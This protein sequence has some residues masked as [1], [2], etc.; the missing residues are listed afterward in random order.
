VLFVLPTLK[1]ITDPNSALHELRKYLIRS[2]FHA[3]SSIQLPSKLLHRVVWQTNLP[4]SVKLVPLKTPEK[5]NTIEYFVALYL[6]HNEMSDKSV[7]LKGRPMYTACVPRPPY[8]RERDLV[9][10][11]QKAG[12]AP[13]PAWTYAE[14]LAPPPPL[15]RFEPRTVQSVASRYTH[16]AVPVPPCSLVYRYQRF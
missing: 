4:T 11:V 3:G 5:Q 2:G 6:R 9:P 7:A 8:P 16:F 12:W 14:N 10:T 1:F 13:G 15:P